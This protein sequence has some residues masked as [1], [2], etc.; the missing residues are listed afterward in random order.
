MN[1]SS[2]DLPFLLQRFFPLP[3]NAAWSLTKTLTGVYA[4][5]SAATSAAWT[6]GCSVS[7]SCLYRRQRWSARTCQGG[8]ARTCRA[9]CV[10]RPTAMFCHCFDITASMFE[11]ASLPACSQ[12]LMLMVHLIA[13]MDGK[14]IFVQAV[15]MQ[16]CM[17]VDCCMWAQQ[18]VQEAQHRILHDQ[19]V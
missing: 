2:P 3:P 4:P 17:H 19:L 11:D 1:D 6:W 12:C 8:R 10:D 5:C 16:K 13:C 14:I 15:H 9:K 7:T 18:N